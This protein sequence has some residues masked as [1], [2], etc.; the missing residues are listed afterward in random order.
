MERLNYG[1][2]Y[3][4]DDKE[5][6]DFDDGEQDHHED[7][8]QEYQPGFRLDPDLDH[9]REYETTGD[10]QDVVEG[11]TDFVADDEFQEGYLR[12]RLGWRYRALVSRQG[13]EWLPPDTGGFLGPVFVRFADLQGRG[14]DPA[15]D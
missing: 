9:E 12:R 7:H 8:T 2:G 6:Y 5:D 15:A 13:Q 3:G 1:R 10:L 4:R 11:Q 14:K